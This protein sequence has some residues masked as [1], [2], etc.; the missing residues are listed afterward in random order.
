MNLKPLYYLIILL[1]VLSFFPEV[2][3]FYTITNADQYTQEIN[4]S[5]SSNN[6][7]YSWQE[8]Y[9]LEPGETIEVKKPL[10]LVI[11]W[12][13]PFKEE[14]IFHSVSEYTY[15]VTLG[16]YQYITDFEPGISTGISLELHNKS[17]E[18]P[19]KIIEVEF[20]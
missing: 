7:E 19:I 15:I 8:Y 12:L 14:D 1:V 16:E 17:I 13:N 5:I 3:P 4:I 6:D 9:E 18:F 20:R 11:K 10:S 2:E